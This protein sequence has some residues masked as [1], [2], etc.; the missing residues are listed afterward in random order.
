MWLRCT[1]RIQLRAKHEADSNRQG[2]CSRCQG[3]GGMEISQQSTVSQLFHHDQPRRGM[4]QGRL[5]LLWIL[6]LLGM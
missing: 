1:S 6:F 5:L 4:Q 2:D 3:D